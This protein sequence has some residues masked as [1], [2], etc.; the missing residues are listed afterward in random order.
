MAKA[1]I[2]CLFVFTLLFACAHD[3]DDA[4]PG[5]ELGPCVQAQYCE[6]PLVCTDGICVHPDQL[7]EDDGGA[8][9]G[10]VRQ[11]LG[12]GQPMPGEDSSPGDSGPSD[13]TGGG[14]E[15]YCSHS[16]EGACICGHTADYGPLDQPCSSATVGSPSH[17]CA[18]EGWPGYG[19]CSCWVQSCRRISSDTCLCGIGDV[20]PEDEPVSGCTPDGGICCHDGSSCACWTSI[21]SCLEGATPV[22]SC[23]VESL[24]CGEGSTKL[25]ACN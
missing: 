13:G 25:S 18:S 10:V 7:A 4:E 19:G 8:D 24:G 2:R 23:S 12:G 15:V 17:C 21:T 11:D 16:E 5:H 6:Q 14:A 22:E 1:M 9:D 3:D 20:D